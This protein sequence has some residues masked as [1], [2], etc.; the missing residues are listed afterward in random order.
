MVEERVAKIISDLVHPRTKDL[1]TA[2]MAVFTP[3]PT[4]MH[5]KTP[6]GSSSSA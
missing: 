6:C 2:P 4:S 5:E 3:C 1:E